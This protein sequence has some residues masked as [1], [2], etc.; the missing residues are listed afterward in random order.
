MDQLDIL[1]IIEFVLMI[2][3]IILIVY[4]IYLDIKYYKNIRSYFD[5][6]HG[7]L[8]YIINS[9]KQRANTSIDN[10]RSTVSKWV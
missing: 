4:K 7:K 3:L 1:S 9:L 10:D 8:Q 6:I 2:I 5:N